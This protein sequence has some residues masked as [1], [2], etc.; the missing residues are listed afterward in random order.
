MNA[1]QMNL[2]LPGAPEEKSY[3]GANAV[4]LPYWEHEGKII[5]IALSDKLI[6]PVTNQKGGHIYTNVPD[7]GRLE[8]RGKNAKI[9]FLSHAAALSRSLELSE[10]IAGHGQ[11][12]IRDAAEQGELLRAAETRSVEMEAEIARL[13]DELA[14]AKRQTPRVAEQQ[15][16][17]FGGGFVLVLRPD[18]IRAVKNLGGDQVTM[19]QAFNIALILGQLLYLVTKG[20]GKVMADGLRYIYGTYAE[21]R[22]RYFFFLSHRTIERTFV[23]AESLGL[24]TSKQPEGRFSRRKYYAP[25]EPAILAASG[26]MATSFRQNGGLQEAAKMAPSFVQE[27]KNAADVG[28]AAQ[29]DVKRAQLCALTATTTDWREV[30]EKLKPHFPSHDVAFQ[31]RRYRKWRND[32]QL[33]LT[34]PTF[35]DWMLRADPPLSPPKHRPPAP[36]IAIEHKEEIDPEKH[37]R[38]LKDLEDHKAQEAAKHAKAPQPE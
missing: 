9:I 8:F 6:L 1:N 38:F 23:G 3:P 11:S 25:S 22:E 18:L 17:D 28:D 29:L 14:A 37:A 20:C 24:L 27:N 35:V 36:P 19:A 31:M 10:S 12:I 32:R 16:I 13:R 33:P 21:F 7:Y 26:K 15:P 34:A 2:D 5:R 4:K 30:V